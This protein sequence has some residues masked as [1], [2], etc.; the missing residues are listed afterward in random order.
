MNLK[1]YLDNYSMEPIEAAL[2]FKIGL[3]SMYRYLRGGKM[4]RTTARKIEKVTKG[5]VS[6]KELMKYDEVNK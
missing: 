6:Y 2:K 3:T 5:E 4:H 1:Q